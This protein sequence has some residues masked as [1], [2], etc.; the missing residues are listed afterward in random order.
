MYFI[1][2]ICCYY[3]VRWTVNNISVC[4]KVNRQYK[5]NLS[6][7][8]HDHRHLY[9]RITRSSAFHKQLH[10]YLLEM[11]L[12]PT[13]SIPTDTVR[14]H[15]TESCRNICWKCPLSPTS[16]PT[17]TVRRHFTQSCIN[18]YWKC[19][20]HRRPYQRKQSVGISQRVA[21]IF[22][23]NA[24]ITNISTGGY[25]PSAFH[26]ELQT[27]LLEMLL[28]LTSIPMDRGAVHNY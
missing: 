23:G 12:S 2:V 21:K 16:L 4:R 27:Y 6:C 14:R 11:T 10:K 18:I 13:S 8:V 19:H 20:Y 25:N 9:Q 1:S 3:F 17:D 28:S 26:R 7:I 24:T 22:V 15:F 5:H